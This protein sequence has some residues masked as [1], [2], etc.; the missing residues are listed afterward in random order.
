M[1]TDDGVVG[2]INLGNPNE[3][4]IRELAEQVIDLTGS[5]SKIIFKPLPQDDP[6]QRQP[7]ITKARAELNWM[8]TTNLR[9]GLAKT[10]DYF[11]SLQL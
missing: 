2:P 10:I 5:K 6:K 1:A 9:E 4:T 7:D 3:F 8:P 11:S